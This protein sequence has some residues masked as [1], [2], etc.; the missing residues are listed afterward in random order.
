LEE[1]IMTKQPDEGWRGWVHNSLP[2]M[3]ATSTAGTAGFTPAPANPQP[4]GMHLQPQFDVIELLPPA[5]AERLRA[6]RQRSADA[7]RLIPEFEAIRE[8]S[9]AR[10]EAENALKRLTDHPQDFGHNL[11]PSDARV[12]AATKHLEKMT[13]DFQRLKELQEVRT[14]AWQAASGA[15][16]NAETWLKRG[17]PGNTT[18]EAVE[19]VEPKLAKGEGTLDGI[20]RLRRRCRELRADLHRIASAPFPNAYA[21]QQMREQIE[22]LAMQGAPSV[23]ALI[24]FDGKI[25]F[26]TARVQSQVIGAE[27]SLAFAELPDTAWVVWLHR[28][29]LIKR[30]DAEIDT[31]ADD[32]AA[33]SHEARQKAEA[34]VQGDLLDV[35]RQEAALVWQAQQSL[36]PCEHRSD[37]APQA[38]LGVKLVT[39]PRAAPPP[40]S[41]ERAS[42]DLIGGRR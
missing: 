15:L 22:A 29:A 2:K 3:E 27:R 14:A 16:A 10:I 17:R 38:I 5:A 30:L 18:L 28:D 6:L 21:K 8:A 1:I 35:E 7:H 26:P 36:L 37:C 42:Y 31:E 39:T 19:V 20:E 40:S 23:S 33:L 12:T 41:P 13:A 4:F 9:M 11:P 24:E 32:K 34:E 25:E